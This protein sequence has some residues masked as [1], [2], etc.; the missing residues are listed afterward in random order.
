[1]GSPLV[2]VVIPVYNAEK[3]LQR[4]IDSVV[5]QS[6]R[7][8]EIL[9]VDDGSTD[10]STEIMAQYERSDERVRVIERPN[11][12]AGAARNA[13]LSVAKG[14]YL[15]FLDS[16][17]FFELDMLELASEKADR[18]DADVVAFGAW[19]YDENRD[20]NRQAS[21]VFRK[22]IVPTACFSP[23]EAA[24]NLFSLFGNYTWNK[25]FRRDFVLREGVSFQEIERT[26]DLLFTCSALALAKRIA[27]MDK[28]LVHYRVTNHSSLQSTN[29][30]SPL[31][32][33][34]AF[35]ALWHFLCERGLSKE[36][37]N[38]FVCHF[39]DAVVSNCNSMKT[40]DGLTEVRDY[41][42]TSIEPSFL[43]SRKA[44]AAKCDASLLEQYRMLIGCELADYLLFVQKGTQNLLD[45][46]SWYLDWLEW[47]SWKTKVDLDGEI[48]KLRNE[49]NKLEGELESAEAQK[50]SILESYSYKIGRIVT[51][52]ARHLLRR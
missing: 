5:S 15:S 1:M 37:E 48:L 19:L 2:S 39:V 44:E 47:Q 25:L 4:C 10:S 7:D 29:D 28:P 11:K 49:K 13:G 22:D 18:E 8:I 23:K 52:P 33:A 14:R 51:A 3:Y 21:W 31:C 46:Q 12:G 35:E 42:S 32:F 30:K 6:L 50:Q 34:R 43:L 45:E 38:S 16:D 27:P 17:D 9:L 26:N 40:L 41:V 36:F 20:A 24:S